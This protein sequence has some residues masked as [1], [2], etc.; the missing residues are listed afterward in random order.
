VLGGV[1]G[2]FFMKGVDDGTLHELVDSA[3]T[4]SVVEHPVVGDEFQDD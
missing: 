4:F 3:N 1:S 2:A